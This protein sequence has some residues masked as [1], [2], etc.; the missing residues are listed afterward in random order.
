ME[1]TKWYMGRYSQT[2]H[3]SGGFDC[4]RHYSIALELNPD[5]LFRMV[6]TFIRF[7]SIPCSGKYVTTYTG[8]YKVSGDTGKKAKVVLL[9]DQVEKETD[10]PDQDQPSK[11]PV[12]SPVKR[13]ITQVVGSELSIKEFK[14]LMDKEPEKPLEKETSAPAAAEWCVGDYKRECKVWNK[15]GGEDGGY[16]EVQLKPDQTFKVCV[17]WEANGGKDINDYT[18]TGNYNILLTLKNVTVA[19]L[20]TKEVAWKGSGPKTEMANPIFKVLVYVNRLQFYNPP[21]TF[22][23]ELLGPLSKKTNVFPWYIGSY[24][25]RYTGRGELD[26]SCEGHRDLQLMP[27]NKF[28]MSDYYT[29][30]D[31]RSDAWGFQDE[32]SYFG[33]YEVTEDTGS[34]AKVK[35]V[36]TESVIKDSGVLSEPNQK[37]APKPLK[38]FEIIIDKDNVKFEGATDKLSK[39]TLIR[40]DYYVTNT[41]IWYRS[42]Y[43][44]EYEC[45]RESGLTSSIYV[46]FYMLDNTAYIVDIRDKCND[47]EKGWEYYRGY[48]GNVVVESMEDC[49]AKLKLVNTSLM[50][51]DKDMENTVPVDLDETEKEAFALVKYSQMKFLKVPKGVEDPDIILHRIDY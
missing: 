27:N 8:K 40:K 16:A 15:Q 23:K 37:Y 36:T 45:K 13:F 35:L 2:W 32:T 33:G 6:Y 11:S 38:N 48:S 41:P 12:S 14:S 34:K 50:K 42:Q 9:I 18:Y 1:A 24:M 49:C 31:G 10:E 39:E 26:G 44:S 20:F 17:H 25:Y 7:Y 5:G 19:K 46:N 43:R 28:L 3:A 30:D 4:K 21:S 29:V 51:K 22:D 47:S